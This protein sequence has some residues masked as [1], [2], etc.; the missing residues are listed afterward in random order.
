MCPSL[1]AGGI[2]SAV[3]V[4]AEVGHYSLRR[5]RVEGPRVRCPVCMIVVVAMLPGTEVAE[6]AGVLVLM[7]L[8][9][10]SWGCSR[11]LDLD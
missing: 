4:V 11:H 7:V 2:Q 10:G 5:H 6:T 8:V 1:E 9:A 3:R